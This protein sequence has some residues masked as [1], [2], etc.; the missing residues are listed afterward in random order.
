MKRALVVGIA[1]IGTALG[2]FAQEIQTRQKTSPVLIKEVKPL[3]PA[4]MLRRK[5]SGTVE[6][7]AVILADGTVGDVTIT[8]SLDL[9]A[10]EEAI[11]AVKQWRF[12][13]ATLDGKPVGVAVSIELTFGPAASPSVYRIQ[14]GVTQPIVIKQVKAI[15]PDDARQTGTTGAVMLE[16]VVRIDGTI[17]GIIVKKSVD[18][19]VDD[20]AIAALSQWE[21]KPGELDG[22]PVPVIV[23]IEMRFTLK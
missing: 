9:D 21:F 19:T 10:D 4:G 3:T 12:R 22:R 23:Q 16:G 8:R 7:S 13:P 6:A 20:A 17:S 2:I 15:Y 18:P 14:D 5:V 11:R 1:I